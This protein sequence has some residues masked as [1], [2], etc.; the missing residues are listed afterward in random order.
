MLSLLL[1]SFVAGILTVAAPCVLPL[2]PVIVGGSMVRTD[3]EGS[4]PDRQ[5]LR[6]LVIALSLAGSVILFTLLLKAT[7]ALL[8]VPQV[9]WQLIAGGIVFLFGL[10]MLFPQ[11]WERVMTATGMQN[12]ANRALDRSYRRGGIGGDILLGAA[13]GPTFSSCSPTYA[14]ILAAVLPVSFAE[15]LIYIV[16]YALGLAVTLMM[17]GLLGQAF[18][19][20]LGWLTNPSGWL[21]R[22]IGI[23]LILVGLAVIFGLD[24]QFQTFV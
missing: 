18:A 15:G 1:L 3:A 9:M 8:G 23:L 10:T 19:R 11:L 16:V 20:K 12:R 2:L 24:K 13:L 17:V 7:T 4:R 6:P 21:R 5:W 14:L 22:T